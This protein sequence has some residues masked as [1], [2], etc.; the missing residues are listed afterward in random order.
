M[1]NPQASPLYDVAVIGG[2]IIGCAAACELAKTD[3]RV[4]LIERDNDVA[5]GATRANSGIVHAGY[6]PCRAPRWP[7]TMWKATP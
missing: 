5:M 6:D 3:A 2:G 1:K 4:I 7:G